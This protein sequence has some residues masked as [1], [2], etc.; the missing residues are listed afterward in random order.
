M[1]RGLALPNP[2]ID[3]LSQ[4]MH[5]VQNEWGTDGVMGNFLSQAYQ[6]FQVEVGL[7]GNIFDYSFE[8]YGDLA[9][10]GFFGN[11]WQL[12]WLFGAWFRICNTFDILHLWQDD[13]AVMEAIADTGIFSQGELVQIN[14]F[15][16]HKMFHSIEDLTQCG[17]ITVHPTMFLQEEGESYRDYFPA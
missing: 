7:H 13:R 3:V 5:L 1:F 8:D 14:R 12:L 17:G 10:Y 6:L 11:M 2:N 16:H 4:K 9:M 15:H